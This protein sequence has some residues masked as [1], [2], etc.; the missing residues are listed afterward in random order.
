MK[1]I[2]QDGQIHNKGN[3][4]ALGG[5]MMSRPGSQVCRNDSYTPL[6]KEWN[7]FCVDFPHY[8]YAFLRVAKKKKGTFW[9]QLRR[10]FFVCV[11]DRVQA[12]R[13]TH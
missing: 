1:R 5:T 8:F 13:N 4:N 11:N 10:V 6:G 9:I 3:R 12:L 7:I 2:K